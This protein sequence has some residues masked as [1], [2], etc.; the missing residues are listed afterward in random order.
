MSARAPTDRR[1]RRHRGLIFV[2]GVKNGGSQAAVTAFLA[3][4]EERE[5]AARARL[6]AE[7]KMRLKAE[8]QLRYE[9]SMRSEAL[10]AAD[11]AQ[12]EQLASE[13]SQATRLAQDAAA[14][15][16]LQR[17]LEAETAA[18]KCNET[19]VAQWES[20]SPFFEQ[21]ESRALAAEA[22]QVALA[23]ELAEGK[24]SL[25]AAEAAAAE[26]ESGNQSHMEEVERQSALRLSEM[27]RQLAELSVQLSQPA[28][29]SPGPAIST[30]PTAVPTADSHCSAPSLSASELDQT[31]PQVAVRAGGSGATPKACGCG[32]EAP[33]GQPDKLSEFSPQQSLSAKNVTSQQAGPDQRLPSL[34]HLDEQLAREREAKESLRAEQWLRKREELMAA[35]NQTMVE[36]AIQP[37]RVLS[38]EEL[39]QMK[40]FRLGAEVRDLWKR[41]SRQTAQLTL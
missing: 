16:Q 27:D 10:R 34:G 37:K 39:K 1:R 8:R 2:A 41:Y 14:K 21:L 25:L 23:S 7:R 32:S 6:L 22:G 33:G 26:V 3:A 36:R 11:K 24:R 38:R 9:R 17:K 13:H 4:G 35:R 19:E 15:A 5:R 20:K 12:Q 30:A 40:M 31:S 18:R 28:H 29:S